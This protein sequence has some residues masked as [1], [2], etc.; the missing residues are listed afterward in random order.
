MH[1]PLIFSFRL[2]SAKYTCLFQRNPCTPSIRR[3]DGLFG[4]TCAHVAF[5]VAATLTPLTEGCSA[6]SSAPSRQYAPPPPVRRGSS[7][8]KLGPF[9]VLTLLSFTPVWTELSS[10][11]SSGGGDA[12]DR[13][14]DVL[15]CV[16]EE[17]ACSANFPLACNDHFY[18]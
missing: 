4:T 3:G 12:L 7:R 1:P 18:I 5:R 11:L 8:R 10:T 17:G 6:M 9:T 15:F 14:R 16:V 13:A 2:Y